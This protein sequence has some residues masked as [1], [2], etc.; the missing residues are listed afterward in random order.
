MRHIL[1]TPNGTPA[2]IGPHSDIPV[3]TCAHLN[4]VLVFYRALRHIEAL[5]VGPVRACARC[6]TL[7]TNAATIYAEDGSVQHYILHTE[8]NLGKR[9]ELPDKT[10]F[11]QRTFAFLVLS[12]EYPEGT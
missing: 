7:I 9:R 11:R 2:S 1:T 8:R 3:F 12:H 5:R 10:W 4:A 6:E